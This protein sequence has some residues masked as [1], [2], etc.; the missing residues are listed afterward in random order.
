VTNP[1]EGGVLITLADIYK[2]VVG[3]GAR[4][5]TVLSK[6][7]RVEQIVAEHDAELRPL[8]GAAERL[9]DHEGRLRSLERA[10]WPLPSIT[11]LIALGSAA[12]AL[13]ALIT[14]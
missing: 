1:S 7:E 6:H 11:I 14:R 3:V 8:A 4:L 13:V 2:L 5:D 12:V 9:V 10:R